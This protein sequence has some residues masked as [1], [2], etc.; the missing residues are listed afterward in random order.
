M[1]YRGKLSEHCFTFQHPSTCLI[2]G[3]T[4][5]GKT[6]FVSKIIETLNSESSLIHPTPTRIVWVYN[7]W[8]PLYE[9]L[10]GMKGD[11]LSME[12]VKL[13]NGNLNEIYESFTQSEINLLILDDLMSSASTNQKK[14]ILQLF[15]QGSHHRNLTIFYIVQNLFDQGSSSRAIS[16][17]AQYIVVFKNPRDSAQIGYLAQQAFPK[18]PKFLEEAYQDATRN[19]HTY[20]MLNLTQICEDWFRVVAQIFPGEELEV[21]VPNEQSVPE[22]IL[23]K[24]QF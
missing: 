9:K 6:N 16:L 21:Y 19:P 22:D 18:S 13:N 7:E 12:F 4:G 15:T 23:Y 17:N 1:E 20:L 2:A 5:C 8:Q 10:M 11:K 3:P 24:G 14:Q